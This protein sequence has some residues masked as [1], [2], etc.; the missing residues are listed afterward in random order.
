MA[1]DFMQRFSAVSLGKLTP[2]NWDRLMREL[3]ARFNELE[4]VLPPL[5]AAEALVLNVGLGRVNEVLLPA[6]EVIAE[7]ANLG[8][9]FEAQSEN[10]VTIA[11]GPSTFIIP[12]AKRN[13]FSPASHLAFVSEGDSTKQMYGTRVSYDRE[14]GELIA[15]ISAIDGEGTFDDWQISVSIPPGVVP[16]NAFEAIING[17]PGTL[18]TLGEIA[19]AFNDDP[20]FLVGLAP[21]ASPALTGTP[22]APTASLEV[23]TTQIATTA[24]V[25]GVVAAAAPEA[26][27][28]SGIDELAFFGGY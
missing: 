17:A 11:E 5:E 15:D 20:D 27:D 18:D 10:A 24:F 19:A 23:N 13:Q 1:D 2:S 3:H 14:T 16:P 28:L 7:L 6:F 8:L 26:P 22:T 9:L 12:E 4:K 21:K 25:Q